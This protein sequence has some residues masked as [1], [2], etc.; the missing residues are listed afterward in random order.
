VT[1]AIMVL[2]FFVVIGG[3]VS[4]DVRGGATGAEGA[5]WI[6]VSTLLLA[7]AMRTG[8]YL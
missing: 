5:A 4:A 2:L 8:G 6:A 1:V 3:L 7:A